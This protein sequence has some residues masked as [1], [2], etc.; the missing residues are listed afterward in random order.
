MNT[1]LTKKLTSLTTDKLWDYVMVQPETMAPAV[2]Y[3]RPT[4]SDDECLERAKQV[5]A[6]L[7]HWWLLEEPMLKSIE[8]EVVQWIAPKQATFILLYLV[9]GALGDK[10]AEEMFW[11]GLD[12]IEK[13]NSQKAKGFEKIKEK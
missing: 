6:L 1:E 12:A 5:L 4:I 9:R 8:T 13:K 10:H 2:K 3:K 11:M 7:R